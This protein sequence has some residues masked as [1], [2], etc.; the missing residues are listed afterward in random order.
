[1]LA[2]IIRQI[3]IALGALSVPAMALAQA[4]GQGIYSTTTY[5]DGVIQ[6]GP[7]TLPNTGTFWLGVVC[8]VAAAIITAAYVYRR[9]INKEK[10]EQGIH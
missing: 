8:I 1:M 9:T 7:I 2:R 5:S 4:Y 10:A 6:I 3:A